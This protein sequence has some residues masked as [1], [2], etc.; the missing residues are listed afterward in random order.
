M[1]HNKERRHVAFWQMPEG[2]VRVVDGAAVP[3]SQLALLEESAVAAASLRE[4]AITVAAAMPAQEQT[5][6]PAARRIRT[7]RHPTKHSS[8]VLQGGGR[9]QI[10]G[11]R[12]PAK[13]LT[14]S[15]NQAATMVQGHPAHPAYLPCS[16]VAAVTATAAEKPGGGVMMAADVGAAAAA[17]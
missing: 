2:V 1:L 15:L 12:P 13:R 14:A 5:Q 8:T 10:T 3:G 16:G 4:A 17:A 7:I 6:S 9:L 11:A